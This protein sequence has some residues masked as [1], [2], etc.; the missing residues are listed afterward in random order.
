MIIWRQN[1][2]VIAQALMRFFIFYEKKV[3]RVMDSDA[4]N[5]IYNFRLILM[6]G[7]D[8]DEYDNNNLQR[9]AF[10]E[11]LQDNPE[12]IK[13]NERSRHCSSAFRIRR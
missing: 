5:L 9:S 12:Y 3:V 2:L 13:C 10:E 8:S 11:R 1:N 4:D 6:K 7:W